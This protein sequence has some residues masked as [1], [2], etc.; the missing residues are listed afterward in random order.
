MVWSGGDSDKHLVV[1]R[2]CSGI[3]EDT[4]HDT[5]RSDDEE[6]LELLQ[7]NWIHELVL[8]DY[9]LFHRIFCPGQTVHQYVYTS[10]PPLYLFGITFNGTHS[11]VFRSC[12]RLGN[13]R[14]ERPAAD[15][16]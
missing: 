13:E 16:I 15:S 3:C 1:G 7:S 12:L 8:D 11:H 2:L 14:L 10:L 5:L 4:Q 9:D 6:T